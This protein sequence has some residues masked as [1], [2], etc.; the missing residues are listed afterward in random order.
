MQNIYLLNNI[1]DAILPVLTDTSGPYN[2]RYGRL[3]TTVQQKTAE[4]KGRSRLP[5]ANQISQKLQK[6]HEICQP[7][8]MRREG[9]PLHVVKT[10][11]M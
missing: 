9:H 8:R 5:S 4:K 1:L 10:K 7:A 3:S 11:L 2:I 6:M